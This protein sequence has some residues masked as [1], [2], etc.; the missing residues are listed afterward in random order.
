MTKPIIMP[1]PELIKINNELKLPSVEVKKIIL[2][3]NFLL[4]P[5]QFNVDI[6]SEIE[7]ICDFQYSIFILDTTVDELK[8]VMAEQKGKHKEQ[9]KAALSLIMIKT[10]FQACDCDEP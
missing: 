5:F 7:R 2:D 8:K 1:R 3:T 4:V 6:F 9:A 10:I